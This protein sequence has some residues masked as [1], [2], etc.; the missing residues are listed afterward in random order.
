MILWGKTHCFACLAFVP[1]LHN[2]ALALHMPLSNREI[3]LV[4]IIIIIQVE[5]FKNALSR[6]IEGESPEDLVCA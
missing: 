5:Q 1:S 3:Y 2:V 4:I 6:S